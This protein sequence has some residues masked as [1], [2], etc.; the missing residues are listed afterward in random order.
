M[1][2]MRCVAQTRRLHQ[3]RQPRAGIHLQPGDLARDGRAIGLGRGKPLH[4]HE[5]ELPIDHLLRTGDD[6]IRS[7]RHPD[8]AETQRGLNVGQRDRRAVDSGQDAIDKLLRRYR[9]HPQHENRDN[10]PCERR[11]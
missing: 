7:R 1:S 9:R 2:L 4:L 5:L 3:R 11:R 8:Q 10:K 6:R